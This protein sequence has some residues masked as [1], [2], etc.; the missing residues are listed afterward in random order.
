M[1]YQLQL[2]AHVAVSDLEEA[3]AWRCWAV[4]GDRAGSPVRTAA[5]LEVIARTVQRQ[6]ARHLYAYDTCGLYRSCLDGARPAA[7]NHLPSIPTG[8]RERQGL[9][10]VH[11][12]LPEGLEG[13]E[14]AFAAAIVAVALGPA[15][16]PALSGVLQREVGSALRET[17]GPYLYVGELCE[18]AQ[19][20]RAADPEIATAEGRP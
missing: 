12:D 20:L 18:V 3:V 15:A 7:W 6:F 4:L 13:F 1:H 9:T 11:L 19:K 17:V 10:L 8:L 2:P 14:Q 16:G 5:L